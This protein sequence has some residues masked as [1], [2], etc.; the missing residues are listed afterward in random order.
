[1]SRD[2]NR[3]FR[4]F[5]QIVAESGY[6]ERLKRDFPKTGAKHDWIVRCSDSIRDFAL[7]FPSARERDEMLQRLLATRKMIAEA[8]DVCRANLM[9]MRAAG[10]HMEQP[11]HPV[12]DC[13]VPNWEEVR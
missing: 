4:R 1:M 12:V 6:S 3:D 10:R 13:P 8:T 5:R 7:E 11:Q 9:T 2:V